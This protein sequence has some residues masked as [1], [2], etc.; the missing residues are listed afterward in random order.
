MGISFKKPADEEIEP[1]GSCL[2]I[3]NTSSV[4]ARKVWEQASDKWSEAEKKLTKMIIVE[5]RDL[6]THIYQKVAA[7]RLGEF[8][9]TRNKS[10]IVHAGPSQD[11]YLVLQDI[12]DGRRRYG[13]TVE[14]RIFY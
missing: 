9:L 7:A 4:H 13:Y 1:I 12:V 11:I 5:A 2:L 10:E 8:H 6:S 3:Y 14:L